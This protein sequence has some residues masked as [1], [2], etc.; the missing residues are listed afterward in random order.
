MQGV[1]FTDQARATVDAAV[2]AATKTA[3]MTH[4]EEVKALMAKSMKICITRGYAVWA[5]APKA[6]ALVCGAPYSAAFP[7]AEDLTQYMALGGEIVTIS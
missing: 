5:F 2:R 7:A 3:P 1:R 6:T 4:A